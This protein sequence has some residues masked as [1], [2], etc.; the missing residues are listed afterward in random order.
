MLIC[1]IEPE[2]KVDEKY[3]FSRKYKKLRKNSKNHNAKNIDR[4]VERKKISFFLAVNIKN[5]ILKIVQ[6]PKITSKRNGKTFILPHVS[7][8]RITFFDFFPIS[9]KSV[10]WSAVPTR[11]S[12]VSLYQDEMMRGPVAP[13]GLMTYNSIL[14]N[15]RVLRAWIR[16]QRAWFEVCDDWFEV[17]S[18]F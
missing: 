13:E 6:L 1:Y 18:A 4:T 5:C 10:T 11:C 3:W 14:D 9:C 15:W 7:K 16:V 17:S 2:I 12:Y 8:S